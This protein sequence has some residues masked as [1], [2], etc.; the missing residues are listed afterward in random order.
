MRNT[1]DVYVYN[2]FGHYFYTTYLEEPAKHF[3]MRNYPVGKLLSA[4]CYCFQLPKHDHYLVTLTDTISN[5]FFTHCR[6]LLMLKHWHMTTYH[7]RP[8]FAM[9]FN[10]ERFW[11]EVNINRNQFFY[12]T[13]LSTVEEASAAKDF[14]DNERKNPSR[15]YL[16]VE[17]IRQYKRL[18][19]HKLL[20]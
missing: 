13:C 20:C 12:T 11:W 4:D 14:L 16:D 7:Q 5:S 6:E 2:D 8:K 10:F 1:F 3:F 17:E 9:L 19:T 18:H 15:K